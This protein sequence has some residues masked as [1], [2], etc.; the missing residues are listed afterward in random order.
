[1]PPFTYTRN[2]NGDFVCQHCHVIKPKQ[3]TMH[4]HLKKHAGD[5]PHKCKHCDQKF[6]Q[7]RYLEL[8]IAARH[9]ETDLAK[10]AEMFS[11]PH[12]GCEYSSLTKANRRIHYF[13][14]HMKDIIDKNVTKLDDGKEYTC[15]CCEKTLKSQTS[16]YYH[17]GDC[18]KLPEN[19][20]R[21]ADLQII[22]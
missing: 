18:L 9:P 19:D 13:R 21:A 17:I 15:K 16:L 22:V 6:S 3:N 11:C 1:M 12:K 4:Y 10:N 2:E 5:L 7:L 14:V 8:H 20:R